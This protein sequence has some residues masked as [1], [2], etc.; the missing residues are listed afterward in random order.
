MLRKS[1]QDVSDKERLLSF[2]GQADQLFAIPAGEGQRLFHKDVLAGLQGFFCNFKMKGGRRGDNYACYI[3]ILEDIGDIGGD[4]HIRI[5][6]A[7]FLTN[8]LSAIADRFKNAK[9][10]EIADQVFPPVSGADD[11][12]VR[13]EE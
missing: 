5:G 9:L 7:H 3:I 4:Q 11:R 6:L 1:K 8:G 13:C 2:H 12:D 10:M